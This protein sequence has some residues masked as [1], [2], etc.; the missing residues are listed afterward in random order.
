MWNTF[1]NYYVVTP[2]PEE[3]LYKLDLFCTGPLTS[4]LRSYEYYW[5][6]IQSTFRFQSNNAQTWKKY[7]FF[8]IVFSFTKEGK[9]SSWFCWKIISHCRGNHGMSQ[10]SFHWWVLSQSSHA[11]DYV[12]S[13]HTAVT[14][15]GVTLRI[16]SLVPDAKVL[17]SGSPLCYIQSYPSSNILKTTI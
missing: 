13:C 6:Y 4:A 5:K 12:K 7:S 11:E 17:N 10:L 2:K 9:K 14:Q 16:G 1:M 8:L 3:L 15:P